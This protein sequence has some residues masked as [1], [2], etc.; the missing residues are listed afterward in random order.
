M[1][2]KHSVTAFRHVPTIG[3]ANCRAN[4]VYD[5]SLKENECE[6]T[7]SA[8]ELDCWGIPEA[9]KRQYFSSYGKDTK[10]L[11]FIVPILSNRPSGNMIVTTLKLAST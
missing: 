8:L 11:S 7:C 6:L 1:E 2:I 3:L 9:E 5:S 4:F 10:K